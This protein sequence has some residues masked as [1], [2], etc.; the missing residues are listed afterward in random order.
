M[1]SAPL[2]A[3]VMLSASSAQALAAEPWQFR[4]APYAWLAGL[5]G[6]VGTIPPLP[7]VPVDISPS[8]ALSDLEGGAGVGGFG[9]G[10]DLY[11]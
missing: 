10:S 9:I 3:A 8:D 1:R 6:N 2:V 5:Q 7:A 11:L 4:L